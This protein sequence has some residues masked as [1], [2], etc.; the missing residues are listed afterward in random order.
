MGAWEV[1][2]LRGTHD[3]SSALGR[4]WVFATGTGIRSLQYKSW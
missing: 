2:T 1:R 3:I 4:L